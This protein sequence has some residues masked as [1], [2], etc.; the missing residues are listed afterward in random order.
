M[1]MIRE[2][3]PF[4][5]GAII[6]PLLYILVIPHKW[7]GRRKF[8]AVFVI[9]ILVGFVGSTIVGEQFGDLEERIVTLVIDTSTAYA[10]SQI[11][12]WLFWKPVLETRL[13]PKT[14]G[15]EYH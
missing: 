3:L 6:I 1:E 7:S 11:A 5:L 14:T 2:L 9:S 13:R 4:I 15:S 8:I 12:Y 10:G